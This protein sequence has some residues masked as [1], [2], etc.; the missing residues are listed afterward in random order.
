[1]AIDSRIP[2][3]AQNADTANPLLKFADMQ[4][5]SRRENRLDKQADLQQ[6]LTTEQLAQQK[7]NNMDQREKSRVHNVV[8][9]AAELGTYLNSG[10][11]DGAREFLTTRKR[12]L[13]KRM[14]MGEPVDTVETDAAL[15]SLDK[16]PE[17]LKKKI[18]QLTQFGQLTGILEVPKKSGATIEAAHTLMAENPGMTFSEAFSISKSGVGQGNTYSDGRITPMAGKDE[19]AKNEEAAKSM[20]KEVGK[21]E[22]EHLNAYEDFMAAAPGLNE[23]GNRLYQLADIATYTATGQ[24]RDAFMRQF[25]FDPTDAARA[26]AE[27]ETMID[28]EILPLLRPTFGAQFTVKEGEWLRATM[29]NQNLSPGE[30]KAQIAARMA[31]WQRQAE[32][33][34]R[35][36][37]KPAPAKDTFQIN[38]PK[39]TSGG[40]EILGY[41]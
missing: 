1:M 14:A 32:R 5:Q 7:I 21:A 6:Q 35:R 16:D 13:Q 15:A 37:G 24:A 29:G 9:G 3:M 4:M 23:F 33:M 25:N 41:E 11:V 8:I 17:G 27:V 20:G 2:L 12:N 18:D 28:T 30:K 39:P 26:K 38:Q 36:T 10:D 40:F 31:S 19:T 34:A 22:G